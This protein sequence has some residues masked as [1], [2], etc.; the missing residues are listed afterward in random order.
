MFPITSMERTMLF[1]IL[2]MKK[3]WQ[4]AV[5]VTIAAI[6]IILLAGKHSDSSPCTPGAGDEP[7]ILDGNS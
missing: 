1:K 2:T 6:P 5:L 4:L 7:E 3:F